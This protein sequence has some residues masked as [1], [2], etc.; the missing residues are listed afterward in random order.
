M[1]N[2]QTQRATW[3]CLTKLSPAQLTPASDLVTHRAL[4][5]CKIQGKSAHARSPPCV[6]H[7]RLVQTGNPALSH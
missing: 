1:W 5:I 2:S 4:N 3:R 6:T 7:L